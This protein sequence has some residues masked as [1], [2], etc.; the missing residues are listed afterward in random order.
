MAKRIFLGLFRFV[1]FCYFSLL[2]QISF[3]FM[4]AK[5]YFLKQIQSILS[6]FEFF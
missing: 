3:T 4:C 2:I 6:L 5:F 1:L